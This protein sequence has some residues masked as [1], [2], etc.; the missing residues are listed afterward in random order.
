VQGKKKITRKETVKTHIA[1]IKIIFLGSNFATSLEKKIH[2]TASLAI[3][4]RFAIM[5][6][7]I[8][9]TEAFKNI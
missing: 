4:G 2:C 1:K 7:K 8:T 3:G 6:C 5:L 9:D